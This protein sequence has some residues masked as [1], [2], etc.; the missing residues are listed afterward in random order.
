MKSNQKHSLS[1]SPKSMSAC[2][3][4]HKSGSKVKSTG[5]SINKYVK[6]SK[7]SATKYSSVNKQ[8]NELAS[9]GSSS[10]LYDEDFMNEIFSNEDDEDHFN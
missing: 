9:L 3:S 7:K 4:S 2:K 5:K 8:R 6:T 1:K 10:L